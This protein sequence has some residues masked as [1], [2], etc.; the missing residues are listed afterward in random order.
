MFVLRLQPVTTITYLSEVCNM[1]GDFRRR[2]FVYFFF[3]VDYKI[4]F[5]DNMNN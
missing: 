1:F 3:D 4:N 2:F 5:K